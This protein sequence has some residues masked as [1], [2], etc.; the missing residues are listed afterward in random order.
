MDPSREK[1]IIEEAKKNPEAFGPIFDE[2][3]RAIFRYIL[4]RTVDIELAKDLTSETFFKALKNLGKFSWRNDKASF[5]SWLY[6][7]ATNE[8][9]S[10]WR[11]KG[12]FPKISLDNL[13]DIS[14]KDNPAEEYEKAQEE[15]KNK[16]EFRQLHRQILKLNPVYQSVIVLRFFEKKKITEI[17]QILGKPDGTIKAQL[18]RALRELKWLMER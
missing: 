14:S 10:A 16:G 11:K 1:E 17:G 3:Y 7:I 2:Y 4:R 8:A 13:P 6:R 12:K 9:N 5:S 15:L 18:Y